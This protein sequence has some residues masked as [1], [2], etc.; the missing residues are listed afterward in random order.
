MTHELVECEDGTIGIMLVLYQKVT[1]KQNNRI[2]SYM[3]IKVHLYE[4]KKYLGLI[5]HNI[6]FSF[7]F[8]NKS[9]HSV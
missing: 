7:A 3:I 9:Y 8:K 2:K 1:N 6:L 5:W 4:L